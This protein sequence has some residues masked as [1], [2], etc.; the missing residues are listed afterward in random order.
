M[1]SQIQSNLIPFLKSSGRDPKISSS[2]ALSY[3]RSL[4]LLK[5]NGMNRPVL[6]ELEFNLLGGNHVEVMI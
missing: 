4:L 6:K 1:Y 2:P 5:I 3:R